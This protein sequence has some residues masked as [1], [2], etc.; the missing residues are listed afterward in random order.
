MS[1]LRIQLAAIA[2]LGW[3]P[4]AVLAGAL[5]VLMA[6]DF[7]FRVLVL[8]DSDSRSFT[9]PSA[10]KVVTPTPADAIFA[11]LESWVPKK[12]V[13]EAPPPPNQ[14]VLQAIFGV[15]RDAKVVIAIIPPDGS[16]PQRLRLSTGEVVDGWTVDQISR[17]AVALKKGEETKEL[18]LFRPV[19]E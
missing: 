16:A 10:I 5:L 18:L 1:W 3:R 11:K 12:V 6:A 9:K 19:T 13:V 4:L 14:L 2:S 7:Y 17:S 15:G 8:R